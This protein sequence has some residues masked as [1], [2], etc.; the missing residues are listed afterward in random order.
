[1][2][3]K[4]K[5]VPATKP[6]NTGALLTNPLLATL[7]L[8]QMY[9]VVVGEGLPYASMFQSAP[10]SGRVHTQLSSLSASE[11]PPPIPPPQI[12]LC[13]HQV[14]AGREVTYQR[15]LEFRGPRPKQ[16]RQRVQSSRDNDRLEIRFNLSPYL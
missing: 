4:K 14:C 3:M 10:E 2:E 15:H 12:D 5:V 6:K 8:A 1:M 11:F 16:V 7:S 9:T 13:Y